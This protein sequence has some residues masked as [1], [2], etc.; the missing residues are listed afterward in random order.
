MRLTSLHLVLSFDQLPWLKNYINFN[1]RQRT[2]VNNDVVKDFFKLMNNAV[3]G[4]CLLYVYMFYMFYMFIYIDSFIA[5]KA[6]NFMLNCSCVLI[7][8]L[9]AEP[10]P[11]WLF[12]LMY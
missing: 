6:F 4:I 9:Q 8:S 10:L 11:L 5:G 3:F 2:A 12:A 1:T 7:H